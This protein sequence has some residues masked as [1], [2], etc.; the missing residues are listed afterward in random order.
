MPRINF[1]EYNK[2]NNPLDEDK[3]LHTVSTKI[4]TDKKVFFQEENIV[5]DLIEDGVDKDLIEV[6]MSFLDGDFKMEVD[7]I[8]KSELDKLNLFKYLTDLLELHK[9][10]L[11]CK[12]KFLENICETMDKDLD[13]EFIS[14]EDEDEDD[15][16]D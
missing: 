6:L 4:V 11:E 5:F 1:D 15:K 16:I 3:N 9:P 8:K 10:C 2:K 7:I 12:R 14:E 13:I